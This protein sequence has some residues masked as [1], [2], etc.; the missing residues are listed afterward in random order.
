MPAP[1]GCVLRRKRTDADADV[2]RRLR[3]LRVCMVLEEAWNV[4]K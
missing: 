2:T 1:P 4:F 3:R